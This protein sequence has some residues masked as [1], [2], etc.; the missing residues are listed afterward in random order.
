MRRVLAL[1]LIGVV[2]ATAS[3]CGGPDTLMRDVVNDMNRLSES[4]EKGEPEARQKELSQQVKDGFEKFEKMKLN[5]EQKKALFD[6]YSD[7]MTKSAL[8]LKK[9]LESANST[10]D[11]PS[12]FR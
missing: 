11:P 2:L 9:A 7:D 10:F 5:E 6:K 8:R 1:G 12:P 4:I 3:G